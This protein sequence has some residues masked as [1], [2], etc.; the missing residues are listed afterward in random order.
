MDH[1][2]TGQQQVPLQTLKGPIY[3]QVGPLEVLHETETENKVKIPLQKN[4]YFSLEW[5]KNLHANPTSLRYLFSFYAHDYFIINFRCI[6]LILD[7]LSKI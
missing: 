3:L 6:V 2:S 1:L 5:S 4:F 7:V